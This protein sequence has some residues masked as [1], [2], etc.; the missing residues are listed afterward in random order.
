MKTVFQ[1][2]VYLFLSSKI[3][4]AQNLTIEKIIPLNFSANNFS[5]NENK[6]FILL[7][8]KEKN[9]VIKI[10]LDG[11]VQKIIGGFGW[12]E[13]QFDY[14]SSI[15]S[16]AIDVY[17]SDYNN[18]RIQ[19]FDHNLNFISSLQKSETINFEY[20][21][22]ICL[23]SLGDLYILDSYNKR[24]LKLNGFNRL[25]RVFGNYES[26]RFIFSNPSL[27]RVDNQQQIYVLDGKNIF[28]FDQFGIYLKTI[29]LPEDFSEK[30][31][32]FYPDHQGIFLLTSKSL[33]ELNK[34]LKQIHFSNFDGF[35]YVFQKIELRQGKLYLLSS[36]GILI[37]KKEY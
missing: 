2:L 36:E 31:V 26:G 20:P 17:V 22:S 19:R 11:K 9:E 29:S 35:D 16:T 14:P 13:G 7:T 28:V 3:I 12:G 15:V 1:I 5:V 27:I 33:Y 25:E 32:D 37:C 24:I 30:I 34:E 4:V 8:S 6:K 18:H 21:I 10:D 23:S